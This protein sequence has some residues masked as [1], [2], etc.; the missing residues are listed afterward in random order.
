MSKAEKLRAMGNC[1]PVFL[2]LDTLLCYRDFKLKEDPR[3]DVVEVD[4]AALACNEAIATYINNI[5]IYY[6]SSAANKA[7]GV[8]R[9]ISKH[10]VQERFNTGK[11][12]M[13]IHAWVYRLAPEG[14]INFLSEGYLDFIQEYDEL[15]TKGVKTGCLD[16]NLEFTP[17]DMQAKYRS[18]EKHVQKMHDIAM[19]NELYLAVA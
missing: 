6:R 14:L 1:V 8:A 13:A 11:S 12:F 18:A 10:F 4:K 17:E 2:M 9:E 5:P 16:E 19:N 15:I 3:Y 7:R